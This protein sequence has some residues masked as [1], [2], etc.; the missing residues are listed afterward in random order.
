MHGVWPATTIFEGRLWC[1]GLWLSLVTR[2]EW[3]L[4]RWRGVGNKHRNLV[5]SFRFT[6]IRYDS[7]LAMKPQ[8]HLLDR[9]NS[10]P[11]SPSVDDVD[12][13]AFR[14]VC[15]C[16]LF[17]QVHLRPLVLVEPLLLSLIKVGRW[18]PLHCQRHWRFESLCHPHPNSRHP[19]RQSLASGGV[20]LCHNRCYARVERTL[21]VR[22][23]FFTN[24]GLVDC[25]LLP[26]KPTRGEIHLCSLNSC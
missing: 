25:L 20:K 8:G 4:F 10:P 24:P 16:L 19:R 3:S 6:K 2:G 18:V 12:V 9:S 5:V 26:S 14:H 11:A 21:V 13:T 23:Y 22:P 15:D 1:E 17:R 7:K